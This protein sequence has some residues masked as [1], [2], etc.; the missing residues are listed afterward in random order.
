MK[1][2]LK[3]EVSETDNTKTIDL[4]DLGLSIDEWEN[5][6]TLSKEELL[7]EYVYKLNEQPYWML[8]K[9]EEQ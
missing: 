4:E 6:D 2:T 7:K 5:M 3:L 1:I 8:Y 9:F